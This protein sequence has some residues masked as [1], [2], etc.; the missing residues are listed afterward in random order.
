MYVAHDL[1]SDNRAL[2]AARRISFILHHD[3]RKDMHEV[4]GAFLRQQNMR[5][6]PEDWR[7]TPV[8]VITPENLPKAF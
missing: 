5:P 8:Q 2:I 6:E 3:L 4:F 1:D 7:V